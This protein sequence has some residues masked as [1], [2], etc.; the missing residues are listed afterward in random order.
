MSEAESGGGSGVVG[1]TRVD[2][3]VLILDV[4]IN[5][6]RFSGVHL[7]SEGPSRKSSTARDRSLGHSAA[8]CQAI[9]ICCQQ[10]LQSASW[11]VI[12]CLFIV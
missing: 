3:R 1:V 2:M 4:R 7:K 12:S 11:A 8:K 10:I 9:S 6:A 5:L